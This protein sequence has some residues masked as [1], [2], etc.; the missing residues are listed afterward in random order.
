MHSILHLRQLK[1]R[2]VSELVMSLNTT[3]TLFK[4]KLISSF[5]WLLYV[6]TSFNTSIQGE[7]ITLIFHFAA[8]ELFKAIKMITRTLVKSS[9]I[10]AIP[11]TFT[12]AF[13]VKRT[14]NVFIVTILISVWMV[15]RAA[16]LCFFNLI[17]VRSPTY[18]DTVQ[19]VTSW[20][21]CPDIRPEKRYSIV[22]EECQN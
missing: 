9:H 5:P 1:E 7:K 13:V 18:P 17:Q 6:V 3:A 4:T 15:M 12:P 14:P 20:T 10:I 19:V 22:L 11:F 2:N 21:Q 8:F 16:A